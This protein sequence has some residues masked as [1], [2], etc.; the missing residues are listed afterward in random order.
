M[1][2]AVLGP[3][4][5]LHAWVASGKLPDDF[6]VALTDALLAETRMDAWCFCEEPRKAG[7]VR[8]RTY[9]PHLEKVRQVWCATQYRTAWHLQ[10]GV[11]AIPCASPVLVFGEFPTGRWPKTSLMYALATLV[12]RGYE[13]IRLY[14]CDMAGEGNFDPQTGKFIHGTRAYSGRW[15]Y[16]GER[17]EKLVQISAERGIVIERMSLE[18]REA[19]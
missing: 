5:S 2:A 6:T 15:T 9:S 16:E 8:H 1:R 4:P 14:G 10:W 11:E 19:A 13:E 12:E 3:G 17:F 7:Q 18:G